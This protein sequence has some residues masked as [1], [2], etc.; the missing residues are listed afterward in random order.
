MILTPMVILKGFTQGGIPSLNVSGGVLEATDTPTTYA[1]GFQQIRTPDGLGLVE[2]DY[3]IVRIVA[4]NL[5][6]ETATPG[7]HETFRIVNYDIGDNSAGNGEQ[8]GNLTIPYGAGFNTYDFAIPSNPD[9]A[10]VLDRIGLRIQLGSGSGLAGTFKIDQFII[11]NTLSVNIATNGDFENNGGELAPWVANGPDVSASLIAGN[12]G[13]SAGRLTFDQNAT[14]NNTLRNSFFTF[15]PT[16]LEQVN[17]VTVNFDA[18]SNN[19]ATTIGIQISHSIGG[20]TVENQFNGNE[21]LTTSWSPYS[22]NRSLSA[23]FD[24]IRVDLRVKTN[25]ANASLGDTFDFDNVSVIVRLLQ[26]NT[27]RSC[28]YCICYRWS[29]G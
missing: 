25:A 7:N 22:I 17:D 23:D 3:T 11:I 24:E 13:G 21:T 12:G 16:E 6:T 5:L 1:G 20:G 19:A 14:T 26:F 8:S 10:G 18:K 9:N 4:E 15:S 2:G 29:V 27:C 28:R